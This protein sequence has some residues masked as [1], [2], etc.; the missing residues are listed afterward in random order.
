MPTPDR[1]SRLA[2]FYDRLFK[3]RQKDPLHEVVGLPIPG[4]LLDAGGGTGRIAQSL[5]PLAKQV[6][7]AD[8]SFRMLGQAIRKDG[9]R[10]VNAHSERL[11]FAEGEFERV[12]MVYAMHHVGDQAQTARELYRVLAPGG[13]LVIEEPNLHHWAVRL[14][15]IGENLALMHSH[16]LSP[17]QIA[18]LFRAVSVEARLVQRGATAYVVVEKPA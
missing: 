17:R 13:R 2:P 9:L 18:D 4:R 8:L 1:F 7:V 14:I 12:I 11:P 10:G 5:V 6:V 16:F 15:A 3:P